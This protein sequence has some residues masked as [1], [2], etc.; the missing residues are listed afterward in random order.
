MY[1]I[2][3]LRTI[4]IVFV[5]L[6]HTPGVQGYGTFVK[7]IAF[8]SYAPFLVHIRPIIRFKPNQGSIPEVSA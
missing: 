1:W 6:G 3:A 2:D 8:V 4:A 7:Y 5:V